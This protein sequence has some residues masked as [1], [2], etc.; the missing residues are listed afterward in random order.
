MSAGTTALSLLL[1]FLV[2]GFRSALENTVIIICSIVAGGLVFLFLFLCGLARKP[3]ELQKEATD[4]V[5]SLTAQLEAHKLIR[6]PHLIWS[7]YQFVDATYEK[8]SGLWREQWSEH[9]SK[10][11]VFHFSNGLYDDGKGEPAVLTAQ[12]SWEYRTKVPGPSFSPAAWIDEP[13]G[14]VEIPVG[15]S[16]KLIIGIKSGMQGAYYWDGYSNPRITAGDQ[17]RLDGQP[18][19]YDGVLSIKLI[20]STNEVWFEQKFDWTEDMNV[21]A[22]PFFKLIQDTSTS[23]AE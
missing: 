2:L 6:K 14:K 5:S 17:H 21:G 13:Y 7:A 4:Q 22:H 16:K 11:L 10:A 23:A 15:W 20:G 1:L 9:R 18:V 8:D 3:C 12:I 19:P